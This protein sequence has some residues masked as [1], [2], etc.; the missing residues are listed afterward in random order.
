MQIHTGSKIPNPM[1]PNFDLLTSGSMYAEVLPTLRVSHFPLE[2][3]D[4]QK[5][6]N[7]N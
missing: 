5:D 1:D 7:C 6:H 2:S 3:M 4:K